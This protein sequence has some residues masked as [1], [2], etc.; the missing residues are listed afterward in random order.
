MMSYQFVVDEFA[1]ELKQHLNLSEP[2]WLVVSE[3][4]KN[5]YPTE[6]EES[7]SGFLNRV[8]KNFYQFADATINLRFIEKTEELEKL[9]SSDEF[10]SF[11]KKTIALFI[12]KYT[13][14]YEEELIEKAHSYPSGHGEK[15]RINKE[16]LNIL[17]DS[18]EGQNYEGS[19]GTYLKA[20][21]EEYATKP[22]YQREQ[23]FFG[24]I[25]NAISFAIAKQKKLKITLNERV[26]V[27]GDKKYIQRY[28][29][30][31]Y[32][33]VQDKANLY[34]YLVGYSEKI[35]D[36]QVADENGKVRKTSSIG[37]KKICCLRL[38]RI[39]QVSM[40]TSMGAHL[41]ADQKKEL[42]DELVK[43]TPMFML[44]SP[45]SVKV[46]FTNKGLESFKRQGYMRPQFYEID[47]KDKHIYTFQCTEIQAINYFFKFGWDAYIMEPDYLSLK[48]K[49]RYE[50]ALKT[51]SG[52]SKEE[53][54]KN[55]DQSND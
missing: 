34:N 46:K 44:S 28:Y 12:D 31:P 40:M 48:F 49:E 18:L 35:N 37:E 11:D 7:F 24:D 51:Y 27:A 38:S 22:V 26:S 23:I 16:N 15:F 43:R 39:N 14:V 8:F 54:L 52:I 30:S 25:V 41:S 55:R 1:N 53:I 6:Q 21:F 2:A 19:I 32:K 17:R 33:I 20:I 29:V 42:E 50:N 4:I 5:F 36:I 10:K 9:Y 47:P 45:I 13:H 3:D